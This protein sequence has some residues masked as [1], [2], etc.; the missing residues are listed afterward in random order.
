MVFT[1][2]FSTERLFIWFTN[3]ILYLL[4]IIVRKMQNVLLN[5]TCYQHEHV[6]ENISRHL[7]NQTSNK[8]RQLRLHVQ[9]TSNS[10]QWM[11]LQYSAVTHVGNA[12]K[13]SKT[14]NARELTWLKTVYVCFINANKH[15]SLYQN[16]V[17]TQA[18]KS[19]CSNRKLVKQ[20]WL[21]VQYEQQWTK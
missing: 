4:T 5:T 7:Q 11:P 9:L 16:T 15:I 1:G 8:V 13:K 17:Q 3:Y 10:V 2:S 12:A 18:S 19:L 6:S 20:F 14:N 21:Q